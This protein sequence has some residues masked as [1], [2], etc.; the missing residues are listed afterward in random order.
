[1]THAS[2]LEHAAVSFFGALARMFPSDCIDATVAPFKPLWPV[3]RAPPRDVHRRLP[4]PRRHPPPTARSVAL[5]VAAGTDHAR[6]GRDRFYQAC[7]PR[8]CSHDRLR[9]V[10]RAGIL[11]L[12]APF[13]AI[14]AQF[15]RKRR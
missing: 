13:R 3:R 12:S 10:P 4:A 15:K 11:D 14:R 7:A 5:D 9:G 8:D 2:L 1:M 6:L